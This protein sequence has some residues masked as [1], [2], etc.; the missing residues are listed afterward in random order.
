MNLNLCVQSGGLTSHFTPA[1]EYKLIKECGFSSVDLGL[2]TCFNKNEMREHMGEGRCIFERTMPEIEAYYKE[3]IDAIKENGLYVYQAHAPFPAYM[4][5]IPSFTDGCIEIYKNVMRYCQIIGCKYLVIHGI[6]LARDDYAH[7]EEDIDG[8][9]EKLYT[10][11][12]ETAKETGV[13]VCLEN[14]FTNYDSTIFEGH[15]SDPHLAIRFIDHLNVLAGQECFGLCVDTGHLNLLGKNQYS[16]ITAL[17]SRIKCFHIHDNDGKSDLHLAPYTGSV[18]FDDFCR[19][20]KAIGYNGDLNFETFRQYKKVRM[21]DKRAV[22]PWLR[23]VA[24]M[25]ELFKTKI[26]ED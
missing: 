18:N 24:E 16:Y 26:L 2:D 25:G 6:S 10:S 9:N 8:L 11:L 22:K 13:V 7:T 3:Q 12:I 19:A 4:K 1:E 15:C 21:Q 23:L 20:L 5:D 17:G 14:L